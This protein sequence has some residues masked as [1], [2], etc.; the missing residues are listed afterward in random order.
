MSG[1]SKWHSIKHKKAA[2]DAARGKVLTKHSKLIAVAARSD[3]S[4]ETNPNLRSVIAN[5]KSDGVKKENIEKILKK[6]A[7]AD[8]DS[9]QFSEIFYEGFGPSRVPFVVQ[10]LT[11]NPNRTLPEVRTVFSKNGG[12]LGSTGSVGFLFDRIGIITLQNDSKTEDELFEIAAEAGAEDF[13]FDQPESGYSMIITDFKDFA[14]VRDEILKT[15]TEIFRAQ[16][17]FR[18]KTPKIIDSESEREKLQKFIDALEQ[19]DDV[20]E[21]FAGFERD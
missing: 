16:T 3:P 13:A 8:K 5:A 20:D 15:Q 11:D 17:Q 1:H 19:V 6:A 4:P 18:A 9:V 12:E 2:N 14:R 10:A 21:I 7:G